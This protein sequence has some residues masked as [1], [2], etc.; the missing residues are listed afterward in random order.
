MFLTR[1]RTHNTAAAAA[2]AAPSRVLDALH[3][4]V[5]H[6][7]IFT[8]AEMP[9]FSALFEDAIQA[10]HADHER[11]YLGRSGTRRFINRER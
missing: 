10:F 1:L 3:K 7:G 4:G 8:M 5:E 11:T 9:H 2:A 6:P